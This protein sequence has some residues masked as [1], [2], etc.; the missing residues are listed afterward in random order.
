MLINSR[1]LDS[2]LRIVQAW[3]YEDVHL[4]QVGGVQSIRMGVRQGKWDGKGYSR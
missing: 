3:N 2:V 4:E 1:H